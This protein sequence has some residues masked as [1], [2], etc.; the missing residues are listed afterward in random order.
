M[1]KKSHQKFT[2]IWANQTTLGK[3][4]GLS[5]PG[6]GKKLKE[7]GLR[8]E[9][10][11]PTERALTEG[12]CTSTPFKDGTPFF[13][14]HRQKTEELMQAHDTKDS[15]PGRSMHV[16]SRIAGCK[17]TSNG[18]RLSTA[19]KRSSSLRRRGIS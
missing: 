17:S 2:D 4:F 18:G 1:G 12:Y 9:E 5:A 8:D 19:S 14:W 11:H 10:G 3:Q 6:M 15:T 7:L 13:I 16:S